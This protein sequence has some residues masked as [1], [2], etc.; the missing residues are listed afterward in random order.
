MN[1]ITKPLI[2]YANSLAI[3]QLLCQEAPTSVFT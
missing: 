1:G 3:F 2:K